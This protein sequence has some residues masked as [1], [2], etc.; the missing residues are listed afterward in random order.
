SSLPG[1][2]MLILI[3]ATLGERVANWVRWIEDNTFVTGLVAT[4]IHSYLLVFVA[5][6]LFFWVG[7]ARIIRAQVLALRERDFVT[8]AEASGAGTWR[9]IGRHLLPNVSFLIILSVS[10]SLGSIAGSEIFLTWFGVGVQD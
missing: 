7:T 10:T 2:V 6:A 3:N 9:I 5:L 1:L 4:G 8:A